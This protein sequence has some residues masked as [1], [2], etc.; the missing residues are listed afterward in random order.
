MKFPFILQFRLQVLESSVT[1]RFL[2][3]SRSDHP[4][5][6]DNSAFEIASLILL[7]ATW[8]KPRCSH[9]EVIRGSSV[10]MALFSPTHASFDLVF[11]CQ[12]EW[13]KSDHVTPLL[14]TFLH[15][16]ISLSVKPEVLTRASRGSVQNCPP[17][18]ASTPCLTS[19]LLLSFFLLIITFFLILKHFA[20]T[21]TFG[22]LSLPSFLRMCFPH[23][24]T[25]PAS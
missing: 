12:E 1:S 22:S 10:M 2:S 18:P 19:L 11:I 25:W 14:R 6:L 20:H 23:I 16:L 8:S 13:H 21:P 15:I 9:W 24:A 5:N 4:I 7:S 17:L 3:H